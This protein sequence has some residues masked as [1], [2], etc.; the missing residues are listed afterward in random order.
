MEVSVSE[1]GIALS[2]SWT[3]RAGKFSFTAMELGATLTSIVAPDAKGGE[4][5]VLLGHDDADGYRAGGG[6]H[7]AVVGR[8][9]NR[10]SL[11][12]F[13]LGGK[14]YGLDA[15]DG[16]NTLHG[17]KFRWEKQDWAGRALENGVEFS[18][19]SPDGE[20][21][22]PGNLDV[23][24]RYTIPREATLRIEYIARSD[25]D[26]PFAPTNHSYF[27]LDGGGTAMEHTLRLD[28]EEF[29]E[30]GEG[31]IPTG[32]FVRVAGT[33]M[34][35]RSPKAV[36]RDISALDGAPSHGYDHAF[37]TG[38]GGIMRTVG[39]VRGERSGICMEIRTDAPALHFY[40]GNFLDG[41]VG[42]RGASY[43]D[44][45]GLCFET[46]FFP[47]SPHRPEFPCVVIRG[48]EDFRSATEFSFGYRE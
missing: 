46:G 36:G 11:A 30:P 37:V 22:F 31:L 25:A 19:R 21:G 29:A 7:G 40:S 45:D 42:K 38:A 24:V 15:N 20:Q 44:R 9:A 3:V 33:P 14:K 28:C 48:G 23:R 18:R 35:F 13:T 26:T 17:G 5:D 10:I 47:D 2:R 1:G 16:A 8:V 43:R 39:E 12:S 27:N 32:R 6:S 34:D 4:V 41:T